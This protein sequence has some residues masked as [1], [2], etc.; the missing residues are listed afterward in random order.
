[1]RNWIIG[2]GTGVFTTALVAA[3]VA[4]TGALAQ[5]EVTFGTNW[6]AQAE[7]GGY[8]QAMI[9]GTYEACGLK[10]TIAPG[11]PQVN[12]RIKLTAG[13]I[14]F[15]MGGNMLQAFSAVEQRIPSVVVAADFQ[16]EPQIIMT[17]PGQGVDK[18]EDL[19][20]INL[21]IGD[22]GFQSFYQWM[23]SEYGFRDEQRR[24]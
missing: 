4:P 14:E 3:T 8:Y 17:H 11:G 16:K 2:A 24:P 15:L 21:L 13:Q 20:G 1:M 18:W 10:V 5:T 9:D 19:K 12:N 6:V 7:H 23:K 22:N